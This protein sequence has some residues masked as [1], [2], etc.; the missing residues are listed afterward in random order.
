M[1]SIRSIDGTPASRNGMWS[2]LTPPLTRFG[3]TL[4]APDPLRRGPQLPP[5]ARST[6]SARADATGSCRRRSRAGPSR[7]RPRTPARAT[8]L[9]AQ[10]LLLEVGVGRAARALLAVE[11]DE[12]HRVARPPDRARELRRRP[13]CRTRRRSRPRSRG[14]PSCRSARPRPCSRARARARCRS[15]SASRRAPPGSGRA[16]RSAGRR[17]P[18]AATPAS[19]PAAGRARPGG[20]AGGKP[21]PPSKR[22]TWTAAGRAGL[23]SASPSPVKGRLSVATSATS[24]IPSA[25]WTA[26]TI[27]S[28][29]TERIVKRVG[30]GRGDS[31]VTRTA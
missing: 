31:R 12:V 27:P 3:N 9:P 26:S 29:F 17:A 11:E 18:A 5:Q 6:S 24:V 2:S 14:C 25:T 1:K 19:P 10:A 22:S 4:S 28:S 30:S 21:P 15:R 16:A 23:P 7:A 20:A 13:R 8:L